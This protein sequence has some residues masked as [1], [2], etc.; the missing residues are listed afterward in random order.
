MSSLYEKNATSTQ[1]PGSTVKLMTA[2]V[3][4][5]WCMGLALDQTVTV[6]SADVVDWASNSNAQLQTGDVLSY[7]DLLFGLMLPSG[8]DAAKC[9]ARNVGALIIAG[10]GPGV[11]TDPVSRFVQAMNAK[12]ASL[13]L[14]TAI[15]ADPAGTDSAN[16]MSAIDLAVLMSVYA[17]HSYLVTVS[18]TLSKTLTVTGVN[19]RSYIVNHTINPAGQVLI[20]EFICGKTGT[21]T[22]GDPSLNSGGCLAVLWQAPNGQRR[23]TVLLGA[24]DDPARY[25]DL[26]RLIDYE[27][28]RMG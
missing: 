26:R 15:F 24:A 3:M 9:I 11:A 6:T 19:A 20:P 8:N 10:G 22:Y 23:V 2:L 28:A 18:G 13:G 14:P 7:R 27:I 12:A 17:E 1:R 5:D 25:L 21:V 16:L 4:Q